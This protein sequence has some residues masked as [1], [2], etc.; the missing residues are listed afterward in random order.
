MPVVVD[1][2]LSLVEHPQLG[3]G[4]HVT[5]C[6]TPHLTRDLNAMLLPTPTEV[7]SMNNDANARAFES[8]PMAHH[9]CDKNLIRK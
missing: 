6:A 1:T 5:N 8:L 2:L 4:K 7:C 9:R 3:D